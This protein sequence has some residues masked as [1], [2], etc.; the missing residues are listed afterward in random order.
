[1]FD[2]KVIY[3]KGND[4][5]VRIFLQLNTEIFVL[6]YLNTTRQITFKTMSQDC[7]LNV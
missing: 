2:N 7:D 3:D 5:I 4:Q 1:M 6:R